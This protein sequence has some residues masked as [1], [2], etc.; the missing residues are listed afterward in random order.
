MGQPWCIRLILAKVTGYAQ[1]VVNVN[2]FEATAPD[3]WVSQ[4]EAARL[5]GTTRQAI[6]RL[7]ER[8][9]LST[10]DIG[11]RRLVR[12]SEVLQFDPQPAGRKRK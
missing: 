7:V 11:G 12:R 2:T 4:S 1:L 5:R 3:D 10:L 6:S 8:G 9:R